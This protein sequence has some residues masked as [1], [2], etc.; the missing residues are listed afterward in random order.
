VFTKLNGGRWDWR[1]EKLLRAD[2]ARPPPAEPVD[3]GLPAIL[4]V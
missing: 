2:P 1:V 4:A 3:E